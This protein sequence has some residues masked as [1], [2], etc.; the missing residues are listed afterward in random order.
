MTLSLTSRRMVEAVRGAAVGVIAVLALGL[1]APELAALRT[2]AGGGGNGRG[3]AQFVT[4]LNH[5]ADYAI[6]VGGA[7]AVLGLVWGGLLLIRGDS[8]A[9]G[10]LGGV[11][12]GVGLV[13]LAKPLAA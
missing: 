9:G 3:F 12:I 5:L 11:A 4:F 7:C 6:P 10:V 2:A 1:A 13:L 8:R